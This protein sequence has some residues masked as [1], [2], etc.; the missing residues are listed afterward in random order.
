MGVE[1]NEN[2]P[3]NY[4]YEPNKNTGGISNMIIKMGLAKDSNGAN[5]VMFVVIIVCVILSIII[6]IK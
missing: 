2:R 1:F 6:A 3:S 4:N 5:K